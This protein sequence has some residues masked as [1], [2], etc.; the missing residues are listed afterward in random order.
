[1]VMLVIADG[2]YL[3]SLVGRSLRD[4]VVVMLIAV[5]VAVVPEMCGVDRCMFLCATNAHGCHISGIQREHQGKKER[6]TGT[7]GVQYTISGC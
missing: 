3:A 4:I 7:H 6:D 1:M 2:S 5:S